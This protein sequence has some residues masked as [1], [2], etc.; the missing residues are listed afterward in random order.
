M[1][2]FSTYFDKCAICD[3]Y[4]FT[5]NKQT[6]SCTLEYWILDYVFFFERLVGTKIDVIEMV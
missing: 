3:D 6:H 1:K 4:K 2:V 5:K